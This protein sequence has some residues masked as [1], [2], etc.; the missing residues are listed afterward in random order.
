MC[1]SWSREMEAG[2]AL[3]CV[4]C[5]GVWNSI[6]STEERRKLFPL[7]LP[8]ARISEAENSI[9][10]LCQFLSF[11]FRFSSWAKPAGRESLLLN[12]GTSRIRVGFTVI[13][14]FPPRCAAPCV[15]WVIRVLLKFPA[16]GAAKHKLAKLPLRLGCG[17]V[18]VANLQSWKILIFS[19]SRV[20][21]L[22]NRFLGT[23][24]RRGRR[25]SGEERSENPSQRCF[26]ESLAETNGIAVQ[27]LIF[28]ISLINRDFRSVTIMSEKAGSQ[29][30]I[31]LPLFFAM[32]I[33][34]SSL[35]R[36]FRRGETNSA[37]ARRVDV[38]LLVS[39]LSF[40]LSSFETF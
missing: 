19:L 39:K 29:N 8:D 12:Y 18:Y 3:F 9:R 26:K 24:S 34:Y 38:L 1:E 6:K 10:L 15:S 4:S 7:L 17:A 11:S 16:F 35:V 40:R 14:S 20:I 22:P 23:R 25:R 30:E 28:D 27:N 21:N 33:F 36:P 32:I 5:L 13:T 2:D 31:W 37:G